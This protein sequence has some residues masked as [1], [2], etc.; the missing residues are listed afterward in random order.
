M[1]AYFLLSYFEWEYLGDTNFWNELKYYKETL[2]HFLLKKINYEIN[3][4]R[5]LLSQ[6]LIFDIL[7]Y[8]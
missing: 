3:A 6:I 8:H 1:I 5:N 2:I 7:R 4:I